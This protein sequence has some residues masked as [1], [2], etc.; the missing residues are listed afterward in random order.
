MRKIN[1]GVKSVT[2]FALSE[3][4]PRCDPA[5]LSFFQKNFI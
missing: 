5:F 2:T 3:L 4:M 1:F